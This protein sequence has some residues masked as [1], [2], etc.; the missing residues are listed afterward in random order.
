MTPQQKKATSL[1][2]EMARLLGEMK[3]DR[4]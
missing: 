2:E 3:P 4:R 1:Q